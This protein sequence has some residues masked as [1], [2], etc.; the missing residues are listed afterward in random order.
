MGW[1]RRRGGGELRWSCGGAAVCVGVFAVGARRFNRQ[2]Q[3][4]SSSSK[5][6]KRSSRATVCD[7]LVYRPVYNANSPVL[8]SQSVCRVV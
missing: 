8:K 2:V 4:N 5:S 1:R 7:L 6:S 3:Q